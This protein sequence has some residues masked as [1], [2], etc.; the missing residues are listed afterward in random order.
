MDDE[1]PEKTRHFGTA[2]GDIGV[3]L[4]AATFAAGFIFILFSRWHTED[5][6]KA[7]APPKPPPIQPKPET[8]MYL[9]GSKPP[10]KK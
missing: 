5:L 4:I 10:P 1:K 2:P 7:F 8:D 3:I 6:G 9:F